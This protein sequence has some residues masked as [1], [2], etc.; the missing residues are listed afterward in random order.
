MI[1]D[2][3]SKNIDRDDFMLHP[4]I[5]VALDILWGPILLT[6]LV[7]FVRDSYQGLIVIGLILVSKVLML[8]LL[9]GIM[10][11]I[12]YSHLQNLSQEC[13]NIWLFQKQKG[14]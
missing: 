5:F 14:L 3:A 9:N 13:Y 11:I 4:D 12:G 8:F 2:L 1:A 7:P 6:D 10:R